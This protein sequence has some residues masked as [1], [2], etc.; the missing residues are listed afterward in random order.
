MQTTQLTLTLSD[1][2][3]TEAARQCLALMSEAEWRRVVAFALAVVSLAE[4]VETEREYW[5]VPR[6]R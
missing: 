4:A 3:S 2:G 6:A 1:T 5:V